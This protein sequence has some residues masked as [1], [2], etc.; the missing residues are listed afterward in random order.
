[1]KQIAPRLSI[2]VQGSKGPIV[3]GE[4]PKCKEFGKKIATQLKT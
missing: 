3:E 2:A 4:L 1:L